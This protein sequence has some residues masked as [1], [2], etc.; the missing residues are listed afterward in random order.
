MLFGV[1]WRAGSWGV[2]ELGNQVGELGSF[3]VG[4]F[5][6]YVRFAKDYVRLR[7][8]NTCRWGSEITYDYVRSVIFRA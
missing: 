1:F 4:E 2:E 3:G 8:P 7:T 5:G 6:D